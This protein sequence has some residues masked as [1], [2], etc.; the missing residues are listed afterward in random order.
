[1]P[2]VANGTFAPS[3]VSEESYTTDQAS[4]WDSLSVPQEDCLD[5]ARTLQ[6]GARQTELLVTNKPNLPPGGFIVPDNPSDK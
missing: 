4:T 5:A 2:D 6:F 3:A 1:M